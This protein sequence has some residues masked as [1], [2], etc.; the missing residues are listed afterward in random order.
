MAAAEKHRVCLECGTPKDP[1]THKCV[2][3]GGATLTHKGQA[4]ASLCSSCYMH[5]PEHQVP[6]AAFRHTGKRT[7][8]G[9]KFW[10]WDV[11]VRYACS[12]YVPG[13]AGQHPSPNPLDLHQVQ[14]VKWHVAVPTA[15][16]L[17]P[18]RWDHVKDAHKQNFWDQPLGVAGTLGLLAFGV[19]VAAASV[20]RQEKQQ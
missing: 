7:Q 9:F 6:C 13:Y 15:F 17:D 18:D 2:P 8:L 16:W 4:R 3:C 20:L 10:L 5:R 14:Q 19:A 12:R 11:S 1:L